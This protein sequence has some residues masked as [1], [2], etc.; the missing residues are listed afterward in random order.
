[1]Q[2][3]KLLLLFFIC[4]AGVVKAQKVDSIFVNLYTDSLK[5][6]TYNYINVDGLLSNGR[7]MPLDSTQVIFWASE[8]KFSGNSLWLDKDF[9]YEKVFIKV[10]LRRNLLVSKEFTVYIKKKPDD[11][12]LKTAEELMN[13]M[14]NKAGS[15][16]SRKNKRISPVI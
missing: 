4:I 7:Y 8:G 10:M 13:N 6:G 3:K 14:D 16:R 9:K 12:K 2:P 5:K 15:K 11:E 1:M